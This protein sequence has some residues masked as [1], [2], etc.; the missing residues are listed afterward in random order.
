MEGGRGVVRH[1]PHCHQV[2]TWI[3]KTILGSCPF[4]TGPLGSLSEGQVGVLAQGSGGTRLNQ[5]G[6]QLN[7]PITSWCHLKRD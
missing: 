6:S 3:G 7:Y 2:P 1:H 4:Q 5:D